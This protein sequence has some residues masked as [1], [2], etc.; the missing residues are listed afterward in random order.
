MHNTKCLKTDPV[1][2]HDNIALYFYAERPTDL[3]MSTPV[4]VDTS[5]GIRKTVSKISVVRRAA[6]ISPPVLIMLI[7][8]AWVSGA[9]ISAETLTKTKLFDYI[10]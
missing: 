4:N 2:N 7:F 8:L 6:P 3:E 1:S 10:V 9:A 5:C